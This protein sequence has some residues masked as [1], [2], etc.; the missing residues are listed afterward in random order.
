MYKHR[1]FRIFSVANLFIGLQFL[2]NDNLPNKWAN[3][4]WNYD[5]LLI[6]SGN[7]FFNYSYWF[8]QSKSIILCDN[9]CLLHVLLVFLH[10]YHFYFFHHL[11]SQQDFEKPFISHP[12]NGFI[13]WTCKF[14]H[15][16][17]DSSSNANI[18]W[19]YL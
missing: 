3:F 6:N 13:F 19:P 12:S 9:M 10:F 8:E 17:L 4:E 15:M 16:Y 7:N 5:F 2:H 18:P 11:S 14:N 1:C